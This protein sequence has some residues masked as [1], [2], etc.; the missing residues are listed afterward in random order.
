MEYVK[1]ESDKYIQSL[2]HVRVDSAAWGRMQGPDESFTM[3]RITNLTL[4][5][6]EQAELLFR[7]L[8][9]RYVQK[10]G[11]QTPVFVRFFLSDAA[12]QEQDLLDRWQSLGIPCAVSIVQ[13]PPLDG[14]KIA[15]AVYA[16]AGAKLSMSGAL[17]CARI[18]GYDHY[19]LGS[20]TSPV[21]D[22]QCQTASLLEKYEDEL[23]KAGCLFADNCVRTWFFVQNVDVNYQGV[24]IGRRENFSGIGL[25]EHTHYI[26]STGIE[27]RSSDPKAFVKMDAYAIAGLKPGQQQYLYAKS[28][29]NS[30]S[31]YG[32]TFERGVKVKYGDRSHLFISGTASIDNKGA[33]LYVGDIR[34]QT[35]RMWEN[36][37]KLLEEGGASYDDVAHMIVYLR[38]VADYEVVKSMFEQR[39]PM[40]PKIFLL[41]PV[42]R[43]TWLIEMECMV[44]VKENNPEYPIF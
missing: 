5:F 26:A 25:T 17:H 12:N 27:G 34:K 43:P 9:Y 38:D 20:E 15:A 40:V 14:T 24:V 30:T 29:L 23:G 32:V 44:A 39:F 36:V 7:L 3:F 10:E 21:G 8:E 13:Q 41:A 37:E 6:H 11:R 31:E 35:E 18:D 33:V 1:F 16:V 4:P 22:S 19:W 42:C 2:E 28:H